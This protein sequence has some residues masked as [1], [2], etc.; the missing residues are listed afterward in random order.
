MALGPNSNLEA[1][2]S[3]FPLKEGE[4]HVGAF[5]GR[6]QPH[7]LWY[8]LLGP[9]ATLMMQQYQVMVTSKRIIFGKLSVM[10]SVS[11]I[12]AFLYPEIEDV[13]IREGTLSD[14]IEFTFK[15]GRTLILDSSR[16]GFFGKEGVFID[17][18]IEDFLEEAI[19]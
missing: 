3:K 12:D 1:L 17:D 19:E 4:K 2:R 14:T 8:F 7:V 5:M 16:S 13:S 10:G 9:L 15:N 11:I 18:A 6:T